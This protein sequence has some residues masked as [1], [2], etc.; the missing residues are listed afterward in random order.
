M[1][2]I[3]IEGVGWG[4]D[5]D[6]GRGDQIT[7]TGQDPNSVILTQ[8]EVQ[9]P[10]ETLDWILWIHHLISASIESTYK[11]NL[12]NTVDPHNEPIIVYCSVDKEHFVCKRDDLP[13]E[14]VVVIGHS[15]L[16]SEDMD[17]I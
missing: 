9:S 8:M 15:D 16:A 4:V 7:Q 11:D 12:I 17:P 14:G 1:S 13:L 3:L 2:Q 5:C 10:I 6:Q